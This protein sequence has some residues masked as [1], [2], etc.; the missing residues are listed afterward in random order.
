MTTVLHEGSLRVPRSAVSATTFERHEPARDGS[1]LAENPL[2]VVAELSH[3]ADGPHF[4]EDDVI[5]DEG[6]NPDRPL[7]HDGPSAD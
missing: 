4:D 1:G 2:G 3:R 5:L 6:G 7:E